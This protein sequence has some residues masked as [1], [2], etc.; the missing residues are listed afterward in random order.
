MNL[1]E[2]VLPPEKKND[3]PFLNTFGWLLIKKS[4]TFSLCKKCQKRGKKKDCSFVPDGLKIG[5]ILNFNIYYNN[6]RGP[7]ESFTQRRCW[8][9]CLWF[10]CQGS[11]AGCRLKCWSL[12]TSFSSMRPKPKSFCAFSLFFFL[13][14]LIVDVQCCVIF[15]CTAK[16]C[17]FFSAIRYWI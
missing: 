11:F 6:P 16:W 10:P 9:Q 8:G 5:T 15:Q 14:F 12:G 1:V 7:W 13:F 4:H 3:R 2:G 17:R